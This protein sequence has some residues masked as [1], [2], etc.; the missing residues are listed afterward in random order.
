MSTPASGPFKWT[1]PYCN[2]HSTI[3]TSNLKT[4]DLFCDIENKQGNVFLNSVVIVCP[5]PECTEMSIY[6]NLYSA[7]WGVGRWY[8]DKH[9]RKWTLLPASSAK[10]FP[11]Y[12]PIPI[13][14]DYTEA[15]LIKEVSARASATLSRRCLQGMIRDFWKVSKSRL[16]DEIEAIRD[17]VD[18]LTWDA[19]DA[20]RKVGN[21][22]AHME[23]DINLVIDVEPEEAGLLIELIETLINDWYINRF[24]RQQRLQ[25]IIQ[26][27]EE[28]EQAK[29]VLP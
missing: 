3:T 4:H 26:I 23:K 25:S 9:L 5:N 19:I 29:K 13:I 22:G 7:D 14:E 8:K 6:A 21:I 18:P 16:I 11:N 10:L 27:K 2:H 17:K 15:Y 20:V 24:E 12:I 1:C 28:K